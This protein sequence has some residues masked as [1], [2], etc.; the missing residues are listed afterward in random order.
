MFV[1]PQLTSFMSCSVTSLARSFVRIFLCASKKSR[2]CTGI[3][4]VRTV[5]MP[6]TN[7]GQTK[8]CT[9]NAQTQTN[10]FES[11]NSLSDNVASSLAAIGECLTLL[12][13]SGQ[14]RQNYTAARR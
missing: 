13:Q 4:A 10:T 9:N 11:V 1:S 12:R 3:V 2:Q 7:N 8:L 6:V 14:L 5:A